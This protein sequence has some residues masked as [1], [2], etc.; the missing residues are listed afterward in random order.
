MSA[1]IIS[2][3]ISTENAAAFHTLRLLLG[4]IKRTADSS[5]KCL[6]SHAAVTV[7]AV[8]SKVVSLSAGFYRYTVT[9]SD[10]CKSLSDSYTLLRS[11][12]SDMWKVA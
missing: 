7:Y 12:C 10:F 6:L 5:L 3:D 9:L 1:G 4:D 8:W 2:A 11:D